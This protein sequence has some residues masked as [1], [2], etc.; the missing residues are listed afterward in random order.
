MSD[1]LDAEAAVE[2]ALAGAFPDREV[3][4]VGAAGVSWNDSNETVRVAFA[5][6]EH[7]Y[8]K[9]ALDGDP[10]RRRREAAVLRY[11]DATLPV[12]VPEV[13]AVEVDAD[14]PF[15][16]TAPMPGDP[17]AARWDG[18]GAEAK[19]DVLRQVGRTLA[20]VHDRR[21]DEHATIVD[22]GADGLD[23]DTDSWTEVLVDTIAD[24]R[25]IASAE[26][27]DHHFDAVV[28]AV[29]ANRD[30]L[31]AAPAALLH[32]DPAQ[33]NLFPGEDR[34][35]AIDW[36]VAH[37]GDPARELH[38]ARH[39]AV[40]DDPAVDGLD[41]ALLDGYRGVAGGLPDGYP[42]REPVYR[43][44]WYLSKSGNFDRYCE[45]LDRDRE[46][47]AEEVAAEMERRLD[48]VR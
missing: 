22:G 5:D 24:W 46:A 12:R 44:V 2:S 18:M 17:L 48:A 28:D 16:A 11:V 19:R 38:R 33:P 13:L 8:L 36:E 32:G 34:F 10:T 1:T 45:F 35:G 3:A 21:F 29:R 20:T 15:L 39:Q 41:A 27:F 25:A 7:A 47:F 43:A 4:D 37:V 6:G 40:P 9:V 23:L 14:V 26:R 30:L 31:D 42:E